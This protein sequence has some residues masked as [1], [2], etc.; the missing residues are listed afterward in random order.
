MHQVLNADILKEQ[1]VI[2]GSYYYMH[3]SSEITLP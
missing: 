3:V 1:Y 2:Y